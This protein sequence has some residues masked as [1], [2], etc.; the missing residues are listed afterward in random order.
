[1]Q[2][3]A[4]ASGR[5]RNYGLFSYLLIGL[6][7]L[8]Q[9]PLQAMASDMSNVIEH[10]WSPKELAFKPHEI[11]VRRGIK[12]AR[13]SAPRTASMS[14]PPVPKNLQGSIR[15][16][17]LPPGKNLIALTFDLCETA[18][19][20]AGYDGAIV[21]Y[22]RKHRIKAT[23]FAG[24]H[25]L[26]THKERAMQLAADPLF[27]IG[28]HSW[29]HGNMRLLSGTPMSD[30]VSRAQAA[31]E[32]I[33]SLLLKKQCLTKMPGS[34]N[35]IPRQMTLFRFPYG[36]C[37]AKSLQAVAA[38]G[39]LAIQWDIATGDPWKGQTAARIVNTVLRRVKPG[40]IILAHANGR[41]WHTAKAVPTLVKQ[42]KARG[43]EFV[44]ISELLKAG[45]PVIS[46]SCYDQRPGDTKSYEPKKRLR[47]AKRK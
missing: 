26:L 41:G 42:L 12:A 2:R 30:Q 25:W 28:N 39:L 27:E 16:V 44:T 6:M 21:D 11:R 13:V 40:S 34:T 14:L 46:R 43:Y 20:V 4:Q 35:K 38:N 5:S 10:C 19:E 24:G 15:R 9:S 23:L 36:S 32:K 17:D 45:T 33:H 1:M 47:T 18:W 3:V 37:S 22:L 7:C 31:Y 8:A 29:T